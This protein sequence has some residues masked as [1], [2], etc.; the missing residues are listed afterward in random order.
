MMLHVKSKTEA[1]TEKYC[2]VHHAYLALQG[3]G[4]WETVL[5]PLEESDIHLPSSD[6]D[7]DCTGLHGPHEGHH[8]LSWI[9]MAPEEDDTV[10]HEGFSN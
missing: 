10:M 6:Q 5:K 4:P 1:I 9:W 7:Q 3:S 8:L 2:H